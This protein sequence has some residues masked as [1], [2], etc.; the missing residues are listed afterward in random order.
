MPPSATANQPPA[1]GNKN[2]CVIVGCKLATGFWLEL[3]PKSDP[4][5]WRPAPAGPRIKLNGANSVPSDSLIQVNARV[6][7]YG[8]TVVPREFWE[9][10]LAANKERD[11][12]KGGFIF[13]EDKKAD[14][15]AHAREALPEKTGIEGL[16]P[17]G[18]DERMKKD[19][20]INVPGHP[21]TKVETDQEHL[22]RLR[23]Q[24]DRVD[25]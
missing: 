24:L 5:D 1:I 15:N 22:K 9:R 10:W 2:D 3:I 14:F 11:Y 17:E 19:A 18:N 7:Q 12:V 25:A 21:E 16:S 13:A 4:N 6:F 23:E 8:R 20:D